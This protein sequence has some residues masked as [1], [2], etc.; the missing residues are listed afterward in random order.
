[1]LEAL[2]ASEPSW[3]VVSDA[4]GSWG[5]GAFCNSH[6]FQISW[7]HDTSLHS[8]AFLEL[9]P[10][11]VAGIVWGK[12]W[13]NCQV[14]ALC[15]NQA[16]VEVIRSR[17]SRDDNLMH[18]LRCLFFVEAKHSFMFIPEHIPGKHNS[19]ADKLSRD[20]MSTSLLQ[21][22]SLDSHPTVVPQVIASVL[23]DTNLDWLSKTW[24]DSF[25]SMFSKV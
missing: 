2:S 3:T 18:L 7:S 9:L 6:W 5:C 24:R 21:E 12:Q 8:I 22:M 19:I 1:M 23:L 11:V 15:D 10:I 4:S 14:R 13:K 16:V 20:R 25:N 17:Y